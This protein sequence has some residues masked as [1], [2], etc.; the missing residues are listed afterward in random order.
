MEGAHA[1]AAGMGGHRTAGDLVARMQMTRRMRLRDAKRYVADKLGCSMRDLS[2]PV[3]M[4][5]IRLDHG[6]GTLACTSAVRPA[7]AGM[8]E[9]KFNIARLLD[10]PINSVERFK[11]RVGLGAPAV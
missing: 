3:A 9:A 5:T 4:E 10:I 6:I 1:Q 8:I 7:E 2:D 11:D